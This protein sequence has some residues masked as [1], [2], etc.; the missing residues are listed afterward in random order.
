MADKILFDKSVN[1]DLTNGGL[2]PAGTS[3][4]G[5]NGLTFSEY[6]ENGNIN[7]IGTSTNNS[8]TSAYAV[9]TALIG[10][11]GPPTWQPMAEV[12]ENTLGVDIVWSRE[13]TGLYSAD[14]YL[15]GT[16]ASASVFTQF[17][18]AVFMQVSSSSGYVPATILVA[19]RHS[20]SKVYV[21]TQYHDATT[22]VATNIDGRFGLTPIEIRVYN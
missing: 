2:P 16:T 9:Y 5:Y 18:T 21:Q 22:Q 10:Q 4:V 14:A 8:N 6:D 17:K 19:G 7:P 3:Y 13:A 15:P 12:L 1:Q 11:N 20:D